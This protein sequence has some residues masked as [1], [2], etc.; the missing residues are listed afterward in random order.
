MRK[1]VI[2]VAALLVV[3]TGV[4]LAAP[5]FIDP[6]WYHDA[7]TAELHRVTG[8]Q[9]IIAGPLALT[10][11]P[12]PSLSAADI[13]IA[14]PPGAALPDMLRATRIEARLAV[15]P[16]L[17]GKLV[18]RSL[19]LVDPVL[20]L[21]FLPVGAAAP[22]KSAPAGQPASPTAAPGPQPAHEPIVA[23]ERL[24]ITN[25]TIVGG[26]RI[27][28]I[29]LDASM[30]QTTG[31]A[32]GAGRLEVHGNRL[33]FEFDVDRIGERTPFR[34]ALAVPAAAARLTI[35]GDVLSLPNGEM[36]VEGK[37]KLSGENFA[38]LARLARQPVLPGL[39]RPF[40]AAATLAVHNNDLRLDDVDFAL[41]DLHGTGK[42]RVAPVAPSSFALTLAFNQ[43][44][45]DRLA[46][47]RP[48]AA[49][50]P[51]SRPSLPDRTADAGSAAVAVP[52]LPIN[53]SGQLDLTVDA[54]RWRGGLIRD[55]RLH[56]ALDRGAVKI[57]RLVAGLPGGSDLSL[58]GMLEAAAGQPRFRGA[59]ELDSDNL[60][61]LLDWLGA[62][63]GGIPADRL[64]K[65]TLSS[66]FTALPDRI[67]I[68]D[69]DLTVDATRL[70]GAATVALRRRI[71]IG[72]RLAVDQLNLDA[73]LP[74]S[75][76]GAAAAAPVPS[77]SPQIAAPIAPATDY[78]AFLA[79]FDANIDAAIDNLTWRS[80]PAR[81]VRV[82][83]T[84]QDGALTVHEATVADIAGAK[85][86]ASGAMTGIGGKDPAWHAAVALRGPEIAHLIRLVA[87]NTPVDLAVS[88]PFTAKSDIAGERGGVAIDLDLAALGGRAR[89][90]GE[91]ADSAAGAAGIDLAIEIGHP[92]FISL[93]RVVRPAYQPAG[94]DPGAVRLSG[95]LS[96]T[97]G[98]WAMRDISLSVGD[99]LVD[100]DVLFE[101]R[102]GRPK[103]TADL[104]FNEFA[105]DR[106]LAARQ[107][108]A[109]QPSGTLATLARATTSPSPSPG[110]AGEA[111]SREPLDLSPLAA[112]DV[113]ASLAGDGFSWGKWRLERPVAALTVVD[114]LLR[115]DRL[116]GGIFG[117]TIEASGQVAAADGRAK[118]E[119]TLRRAALDQALKD[120]AGFGNLAGPADVDVA[121]ATSG[122]N[123]ADLVSHLQGSG[124]LASRDGTIAGVDL[125]AI[126]ARVD[127]ANRP[128]DLPGL[129]RGLA[130]GRT[131][132]RTLDGT[133]SVVDGIVRSDDLSLVAESGEG[134]AT[135]TLDLPK[136]LVHSRLELRLSSRGT[137]PPVAMTFDGPL[138]KPRTVFDVNA[139]ESYLAQRGPGRPTPR[140]AAPP[141][142][143]V[144]SPAKPALRDQLKTQVR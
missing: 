45:L 29:D 115:L 70:T 108:A 98:L 36:A 109:L 15:A 59:V 49:A 2:L 14:N 50:S 133:F 8:R 35:A 89:I 73:Y 67:D 51:P 26:K 76:T 101:R 78:P 64:R 6:D 27:E 107:T 139:L 72:V 84:L 1:V 18:L 52:I 123:A 106:F 30:P 74:G 93:A 126:G 53:L 62:T 117:G 5:R 54:L 113:D 11:L 21:D 99:L 82:A 44:D 13:H 120:T 85:A 25:G 103:L 42:L 83:A 23:I 55:A 130:S 118:A 43:I 46:V 95:K 69:A 132:Y 10:L 19:T 124:R 3:A 136:W 31:P 66:Q 88:G 122:L 75:G 77:G 32:H 105:L 116:S 114:G 48:T 138:D 65:L 127:D 47:V 71:A 102:S 58:N 40:T 96:K 125:A 140:P 86:T 12:T 61:L 119:V 37:A 129:F 20:D 63:P 57:S 87:P 92:S 91:V 16:L 142:A 97:N 34:L 121:L 33:D 68:S 128:V 143:P 41:D 104:H 94:G 22:R 60:R 111:W 137:V 17:T 90:T 100:G 7:I 79:A 28:A 135:A 56:A 131:R 144:T 38:T 134:H 4:L 110:A 81:G 24:T 80:Q 39:A 9:V 141:Q 112:I